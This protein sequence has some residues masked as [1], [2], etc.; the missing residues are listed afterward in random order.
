[1]ITVVNKLVVLP[2][3]YS[4]EWKEDQSDDKNPQELEVKNWGRDQECAEIVL[5]GKRYMVVVR[6]L[7]AALTNATNT[8]STGS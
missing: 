6:D 3:E 7:I 2:V 4:E 1:M 5:D 8:G